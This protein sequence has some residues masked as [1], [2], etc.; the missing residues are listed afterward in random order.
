MSSNIE[1]IDKWVRRWEEERAFEAYPDPKRGKVFVTFPYPYMNGPL[2]VG[3]VF[4][5]SRID[6]YA[7]FKRMQGYNVLYPWA[8]HWTGQPIVSAV[9]RY[10][11]GD[12]IQIK[13]FKEIDRVPPEELSRFNDPVYVAEY[14]TR[15][16]RET[17]KK[18]GLSVDWSR[19]FHT[20]VH[21]PLYSRFVEWQYNTLRSLGYVVQGTHPVVWCPKDQSPTQ[22]HDRLE[23][24]GVAPEEYTA[25]KFLLHE[26]KVYLLAGTLRPETIFGVTNIWVN[27]EA[28]YLKISVGQEIW[29]LSEVACSKLKEQMFEFS[30]ISRHKGK[31][32]IGKICEAPLTGR[33]IPVLPA[34]FVDPASVT[35]IVY[36]VPAHAPYDYLALRD[37]TDG[38]EY[39]ELKDIIKA[40]R[41]ISIISVKGF[42]EFPAIEIVDRMKIKDQYDKR[43]E[44][45][46]KEL[47]SKEYHGGKMRENCGEFSGLP[48]SR[49]KQDIADRL[50]S[51]KLAIP[52]FDLA[53]KVVCR[54]GTNCI[55]KILKD[56]WFLKYSDKEWKDKSAN[57]VAIANIFPPEARNQFIQTIY[58]LKDYPCTRKTGLGTPLPWDKEWL[59]ETL[60][61]ST[62]YPAFY[63]IVKKL[64]ER[65]VKPDQLTDDVLSYIFLFRGDLKKIASE[66]GLD[67]DF[68]EEMR[69]E[70]L[71]WYPVNLRNSGKDLISNHL[72]FFVMHHVALFD[73]E[74]WPTAI[75]V[76]GMVQLEGARMSKSHG[77]FISA[78]DAIMQ[79]G[80]DATRATLLSSA[81]GM[82]DPDWRSKNAQDFKQKIDSLP[83][84]VKKVLSE[85]IDRSEDRLD[86]WL[87]TKMQ[88][89]IKAVTD[90]LEVLKTRTAFF[91]A[92]FAPWNDLKWYL[93]RGTPNKKTVLYF[94]SNWAKLLSPFTPFVA[95]EINEIVGGRALI[96]L[97]VWPSY[98]PSLIDREAE[99]SEDLIQGVIEDINE[100]SSVIANKM[101]KAKIF[102]S[103]GKDRLREVYELLSRG[104]KE[105]EVISAILQK[106]DK[107]QR[108]KLAAEVQYLIKYC[109]DIGMEK[110]EKI[111]SLDLDEVNIISSASE[112]ICK[113]TRLESLEVVKGKGEQL[114]KGRMP[115]PLKP[116]IL[117]S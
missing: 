5:A 35:G 42:G 14:Y 51:E 78:K 102:V 16:N 76:N 106:A 101:N 94:F 18:L 92:F 63:T 57:A 98:D 13:I 103:D 49:A 7:R 74:L 60:S 71:Y 114:K 109:R 111:I 6:A 15:E 112:F 58:W 53:E 2:H 36:S 39:A 113:E 11:E 31:E 54:C 46:T 73:Q 82:D 61:D 30:V 41:P 24:E 75:G 86:R 67:A 8:W 52:F 40:I 110:V 56:Q 3:H 50:S 26:E 93:R 107:E 21:E 29:I 95:E 10:I 12:P 34:G 22:D 62:I 33:K 32:F 28:E 115:L 47:Y 20:T 25:I 48:V 72:T 91:N 45:A 43:A 84:L 79:F 85:A 23:G 38:D 65:R 66:S 69:S 96:S 81:E 89:R 68:I 116:A 17:V 97:S 105:G 64:R 77:V 104:M 108:Q 70:F 88:E 19:E 90:S 44:D 99:L 1:I 59:I 27:P 80:A 117:L 55:V 9:K 87:I 100:I 4:S 37:L 83:A